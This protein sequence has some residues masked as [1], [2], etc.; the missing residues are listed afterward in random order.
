MAVRWQIT[1]GTLGGIERAQ[2]ND[3][4]LRDLL[5]KEARQKRATLWITLE[6]RYRGTKD[7]V[8]TKKGQ[9]PPPWWL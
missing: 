9:E 5:I 8:Y 4:D 2:A 7:V 1:R 3:P 6:D